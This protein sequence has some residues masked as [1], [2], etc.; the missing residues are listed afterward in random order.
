MVSVSILLLAASNCG[1]S[2][3]AEV[4]RFRGVVEEKEDGQSS[5]KLHFE[6]PQQYFNMLKM[7]SFINPIANAQGGKTPPPDPR[8]VKILSS[9]KKD[10][11]IQLTFSPENAITNIEKYPVKPGEDMPDYYEFVRVKT[12]QFKGQEFPALVVSRFLY[13]SEFLLGKMDAEKNWNPDNDLTAKVQKL[14]KG[15]PVEIDVVSEEPGVW[16]S[17]IRYFVQRID[18]YRFPTTAQV[19]GVREVPPDPEAECFTNEGRTGYGRKAD[20][21]SLSLMVDLKPEGSEEV[22][23]LLAWE[24][25]LVYEAAHL[26]EGQKV[27]FKTAMVKGK[28][29]LVGL[30][31]LPTP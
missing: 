22:K 13:E 16:R 15:A 9:L 24:Y 12:S 20:G 26:K 19:V 18:P 29:K 7:R 1:K 2:P 5:M 14:A 11:L 4:Y 10:D 23:S 8:L 25:V 17:G 21:D 3:P 30:R 28:E 6:D 27:H 31:A